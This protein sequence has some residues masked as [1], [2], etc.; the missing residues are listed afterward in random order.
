[1]SARLKEKDAIIHSSIT[2]MNA[3]DAE[4]QD[5]PTLILLYGANAEMDT[6]S[7]TA[8]TTPPM[9]LMILISEIK[10]NLFIDTYCQEIIK[11]A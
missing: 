1:M 6:S 4:T 5:I 3:V 7:M 9:S 8:Y 10:V 2:V 11:I